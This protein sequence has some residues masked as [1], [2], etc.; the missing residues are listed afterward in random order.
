[1]RALGRIT[2][3]VVI[4]CGSV[5]NAQTLEDWLRKTEKRAAAWADT[6]PIDIQYRIE[7]RLALTPEEIEK[8]R[9]EGST[10]PAGSAL[11]SRW[12]IVKQ[13][14]EGKPVVQNLRFIGRSMTS[15]RYCTA[16]N[17]VW[18]VDSAVN[19]PVGWMLSK[20]NISYHS[21]AGGPLYENESGP[22][23][24]VSVVRP[25]IQKLLWGMLG[26][27]G[28]IADTQLKVVSQD[29]DRW[30]AKASSGFPSNGGPAT[31]VMRYEGTWDSASASGRVVTA[32][33]ES[34]TSPQPPRWVFSEHESVPGT[35]L[36]IARKVT[37][38]APNGMPSRLFVVESVSAISNERVDELLVAPKPGA[39]DPIRG[40]VSE[41]AVLIDY[42]RGE[43]IGSAAK[44]QSIKL[45]PVKQGGGAISAYG[46]GAFAFATVILVYVLWRRV[47]PDV[48]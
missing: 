5:A 40:K 42:V 17:S 43:V 8:L 1:M 10:A 23:D 45:V 29:Q 30:S 37:E 44:Q 46:W 34:S 11:G 12:R 6:G 21:L 16:W 38:Y 14:L 4:L 27:S 20:S 35:D 47:R 24:D 19:G 28:L 18:S 33:L 2:A 9:N 25:E 41:E 3:F 15:W 36:V 7:E 22:M 31:Y 13:Q 39:V 48:S 32:V 26:N